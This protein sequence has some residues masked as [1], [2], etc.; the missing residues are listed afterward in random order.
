LFIYFTTLIRARNSFTS[1]LAF[2]SQN[3]PALARSGIFITSTAPWRLPIAARMGGRFQ[4]IQA[5]VVVGNL[6]PNAIG[7]L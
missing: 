4:A 7:F 1:I 3:F 2:P 6:D 5:I